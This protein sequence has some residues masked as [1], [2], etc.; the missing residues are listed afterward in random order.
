MDYTCVLLH[1]FDFPL[2]S[3]QRRTLLGQHV[4]RVFVSLPESFAAESSRISEHVQQQWAHA[5]LP[6]VRFDFIKHINPN[7][8]PN[9]LL[10]GDVLS[11]SL[12]LSIHFYLSRQDH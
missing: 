10:T 4:I 1:V 5:A 6:Q 9:A 8:P 11:L 3:F 2:S 7:K 12:I